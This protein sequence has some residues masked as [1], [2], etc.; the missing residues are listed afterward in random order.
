MADKKDRKQLKKDN[1]KQSAKKAEQKR[2]KHA[3][4]KLSPEQKAVA[5]LK[6]QVADL[7]KKNSALDDQYLRAEAE[8]QNVQRHDAKDQQQI[9]KYSGQKLA[10]SVLPGMDNLRR[11]LDVKVS[12][13]NGKQLKQG[14]QMVY[15]RLTKAL[16]DNAIKEVKVVGKKFDPEYAEAVQTV[17]AS[18]EHPADQVVKVLQKGYQIHDRILRPAMVIV[19][20]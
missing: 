14:V 15:D 5:Q 13:K 18:K 6:K 1:Q 4:K 7:K 19:A 2:T 9:M 12:D 10:K 20:K 16:A 8:M 11:A 3:G 17:P